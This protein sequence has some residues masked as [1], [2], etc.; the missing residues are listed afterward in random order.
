[1]T[2]IITA[3]G[4]AFFG[5]CACF[6]LLTLLRVCRYGSQ[7]ADVTIRSGF[8][9]KAWFTGS[10]PEPPAHASF[11][12]TSNIRASVGRSGLTITPTRTLSRLEF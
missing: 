5:G 3:L 4:I 10:L 11:L 8:D 1:M 12:T 2:D 9:A 7:M 6:L